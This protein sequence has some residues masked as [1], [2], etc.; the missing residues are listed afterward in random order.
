[1]ASCEGARAP[2]FSSSV[3]SWA[4]FSSASAVDLAERKVI[5]PTTISTPNTTAR[6][7]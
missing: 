3:M 5:R 4:A 6:T 7:M 2:A 1:M